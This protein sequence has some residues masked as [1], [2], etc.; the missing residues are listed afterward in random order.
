MILRGLFFLFFWEPLRART[1]YPKCPDVIPE[2][3][4]LD[5]NLEV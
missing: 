5:Y 4:M 2:W 3:M 1:S